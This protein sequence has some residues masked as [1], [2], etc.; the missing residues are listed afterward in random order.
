MIAAV[1]DVEDSVEVGRLAGGGEHRGGSALHVADFCGY[2]VVGGVLQ[3]GVEVAA[4]LQVKELAHVLAGGI[5]KGSGLNNG[6]LP[7]LAV[8]GGVAPLNAFGV[9]AVIAHWER[10]LS[11]ESKIRVPGTRENVKCFP[12]L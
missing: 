2:H 7:G 3:P 4:G 5:F 6:N 11:L 10:L 12:Q 9:D 8:A 1:G